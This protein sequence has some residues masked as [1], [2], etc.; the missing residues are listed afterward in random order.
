MT[1]KAKPK[2][3][4]GRYVPLQIRLTQDEKSKFAEAAEAEH[5]T[6]SAWLRL[7]GWHAVQNQHKLVGFG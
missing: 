4:K 5:L 7:A 1:Q 3:K 6:L 2:D